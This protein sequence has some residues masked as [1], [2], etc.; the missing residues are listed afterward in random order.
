MKK[1]VEL[2]D[3][4][5][6]GIE[7]CDTASDNIDDILEIARVEK[8]KGTNM[9]VLSIY[10]DDIDVMR[11]AIDK[12]KKAMEK[13]SGEGMRDCAEIIGVHLEGPFLNP[14]KAGAL[15]MQYLLPPS[16]K[17]LKR[18]IAGYEDSIKIITI[19]PELK[20]A[21]GVISQC[22]DMGIKVNMGHSDATFR[23][24]EKGKKAGATGIT[25]LF[26]AM[27]PF[28]HREPGLAGFGLMD[29]D[30]YIEI[31]ADGVHLDINT[32]S[33]IFSIKPPDRT[34]LISDS[35]KGKR[36]DKKAIY[37]R[38]GTLAGSG[39][40]LSE[41]IEFLIRNGFDPDA[42]HMAASSNP[43]RYLT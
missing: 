20:G 29:K 24:A 19:A 36:S 26:N 13:I 21:T 38:D 18:I 39:I 11:S 28:H 6:H 14:I 4:H 37:L 7:C 3:I 31:I 12:I 41:S 43:L 9:I 2:V 27:R 10:P 17:S 25:H 30:I 32:L 40:T 34:V 33:L 5:I 16:S 22:R 42:V 35:V 15:N 23:E 1:G 8:L